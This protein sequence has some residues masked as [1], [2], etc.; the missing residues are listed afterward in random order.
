MILC[1]N[2]FTRELKIWVIGFV[3]KKLLTYLESWLYHMLY[4]VYIVAFRSRKSYCTTP[5]VGVSGGVGGVSKKFNVKVFICDGQS[6]GRNPGRAIL[7]PPVS[8]LAAAALAK[9]LKFFMWWARRCQASYPVPVTGLVCILPHLI[10]RHTVLFST[11][12]PTTLTPLL[13]TPPLPPPKKKKKKKK[14]YAP[15]GTSGGIV[16]LHR[17]S[18]HYKSCFSHNPKTDKGNL[19]KLHWKIK[20]NVCRAQNLGSHDQ[21]QGH[22]QRSNVC[23]L[24]IVNQP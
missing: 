11:H 9:S 21:G 4:S 20:Q 22:N 12:A 18:V 24:Q 13:P 17:L 10:V 3:L 19:I 1:Q 16:K 5:G 7:L 14:K 15:N 6:P 23:H 2:S 8:A